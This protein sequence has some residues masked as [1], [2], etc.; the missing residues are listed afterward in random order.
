MTD[1]KEDLKLQEML[2]KAERA[3]PNTLGG[4][5]DLLMDCYNAA[6][7]AD[8]AWPVFSIVESFVFDHILFKE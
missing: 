2:P 7:G 4:L 3:R 1:K 5:E 6:H 8:S